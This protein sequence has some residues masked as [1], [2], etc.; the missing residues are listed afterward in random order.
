MEFL[1]VVFVMTRERARMLRDEILRGVC[2][3]NLLIKPRVVLCEYF[4]R[5]MD[6]KN[7]SG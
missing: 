7:H 2:T 5:A 1:L 4:P 6:L 3:R